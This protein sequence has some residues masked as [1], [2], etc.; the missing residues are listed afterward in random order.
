[1]WWRNFFKDLEFE[2]V[3]DFIF[4]LRMECLWY[5]YVLVFQND[6]NIVK[7]YWNSYRIRKFRYNIVF[8]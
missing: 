7:E 8:C 2:G 5:C 1:M 4:V 6:F 3:L